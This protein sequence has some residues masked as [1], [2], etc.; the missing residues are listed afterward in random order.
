MEEK[1]GLDGGRKLYSESSKD[2]GNIK[3]EGLE[4]GESLCCFNSEAGS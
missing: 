4:D 2:K 3:D 1:I